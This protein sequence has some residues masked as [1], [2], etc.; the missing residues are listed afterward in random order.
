MTMEPNAKR[1]FPSQATNGHGAV[2]TGQGRV[3][4]MTAAATNEPA[5]ST[6]GHGDLPVPRDRTDEWH[7][8]V[9]MV[10]VIHSMV[11]KIYQAACMLRETEQQDRNQ[12]LAIVQRLR[13]EAEHA[14]GR[15]VHRSTVALSTQDETGDLA[16]QRRLYQQSL[17]MQQ[18]GTGNGNGN[19]NGHHVQPQQAPAQQPPVAVIAAPPQST[20]AAAPAE[21]QG[22]ARN[23]GPS[24]AHPPAVQGAPQ[25]PQS[26]QTGGGGSSGETV[27]SATQEEEEQCWNCGREATETCSRCKKARYCGVWC[28]RRD[29]KVKHH[30]V[31][32]EPGAED[33]GDASAAK[34]QPQ[35]LQQGQQQAQQQQPGHMEERARGDD[36]ASDAH[37][38]DAS[39]PN[40]NQVPSTDP[41]VYVED[42]SAN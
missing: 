12:W 13:E 28:Q 34:D 33:S 29:W 14:N 24:A 41:V 31:C 39:R 2:P 23:G 42:A 5:P 8:L 20:A 32:C 10:T 18:G 6:N 1:R 9:S 17:E 25:Q 21:Q 11:E 35:Q 19:G 36:H 15:G 22:T 38:G 40:I 16:H 26:Q 30:R 4:G 37:Q 7:G 27:P 3:S